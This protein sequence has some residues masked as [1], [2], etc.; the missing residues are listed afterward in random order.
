ML[1]WP[2]LDCVCSSGPHNLKILLRYL[3]VSWVG[4]QRWWKGWKVWCPMR[5]LDLYSLEKKRF[6]IALCSL[7]RKRS[8]ER[9]VLIYSSWYPVAEHVG[10]AQSFIRR[11]SDLKLEIF[12]YLSIKRLVKHY[13]RLPREVVD[14]LS[15]W[16]L[17][18]VCVWEAFRQLL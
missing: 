9:E 2:H 18:P 7:L 5:T 17:M 10:M 3:H 1:F 11:G 4:Q 15:W 6:F 13:N 14:A 8:R 12:T 16:V